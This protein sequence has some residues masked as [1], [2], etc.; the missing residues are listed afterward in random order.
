MAFEL[1]CVRN[2]TLSSY[3]FIYCSVCANIRRI[4]IIPVTWLDWGPVAMFVVFIS[5]W[6]VEKSYQ[7]YLQTVV[8]I[9]GRGQGPA[10]PTEFWQSPRLAA[11]FDMILGE[12]FDL[13]KVVA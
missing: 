2:C 4:S 12:L 11:A 8:F 10:A 6:T 7:V 3:Y 9:R 1:Q 5:P 13:C